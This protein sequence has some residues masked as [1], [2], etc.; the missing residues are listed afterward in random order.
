MSALAHYLEREGIATTHVSL[1]RMHSEKI[2]PPRGLWVPFELGRPLGA[3]ADADFQRRV[4]L[5]ALNLLPRTDGPL[6]E[7][8][9]DDA[10]DAGP[11][12]GWQP[13]DLGAA[14][15]D[16]AAEVELLRPGAARFQASHRRTMLGNAGLP[17]DD[18]VPYLRGYLDG[19]PAEPTRDDISGPQ[20]MRFACD[21]LKAFYLEAAM[22][23]GAGG[24]FQM[25]DWFWGATA[26]GELLLR[27]RGR[28]LGD[29]KRYLQNFGR[30]MMVPGFQAWRG[31]DYEPGE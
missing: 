22:A 12:A 26:A 19:T 18:L 11:V 15:G 17:V 23:D 1:V 5:D 28:L 3:V 4:L 24:S 20:Q 13:P 25:S 27:L 30:L 8:F 9:A 16:V 14:A 21:D 31:K 10:P 29:D 2:R 6:L 7:D